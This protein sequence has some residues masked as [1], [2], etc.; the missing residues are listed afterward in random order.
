MDDMWGP[1]SSFIKN[2]SCPTKPFSTFSQFLIAY[3]SQQFF[4]QPN[5]THLRKRWT[6]NY[7]PGQIFEGE[8]GPCQPASG[9]RTEATTR[10]E[11]S[12]MRRTAIL[13]SHAGAGRRGIQ[14][15]LAD[16][17]VCPLSKKP[18]R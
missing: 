13:F 5:Q 9:C 17:L 7:G 15:A 4:P 18:L 14:Q 10:K 1:F 16:A 8:L 3:T 12:A 11:G 6:K 2:H